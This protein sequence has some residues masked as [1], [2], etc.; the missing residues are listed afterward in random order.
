MTFSGGRQVEM[1]ENTAYKMV[2]KTSVCVFIGRILLNSEMY[3]H[4]I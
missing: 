4:V 3:F 2:Y 1:A